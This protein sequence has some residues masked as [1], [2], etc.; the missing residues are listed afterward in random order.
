VRKQKIK[1]VEKQLEELRELRDRS[2]CRAS[3]LKRVLAILLVD[4]AKLPQL[5][6]DLTGF[7]QKYA[8]DLRKKYLQRGI[9][10]LRSKKK[11]PKEL[12]TRGQRAQIAKVLTTGLPKDFGFEA[13]TWT[14]AILARIIEEQFGVRYKSRTSLY[15]IFRQAKFTYHKPD[16]QYKNRKQDLID[17]WKQKVYPE[18]QEA[19]KAPHTVVLVEDEMMLSTQTTTQKVWLPQ[20]QFPK[21]DVSSKRQIRCIYGFLNLKTGKEHAFMT[22][23]ANSIES[24]NVL[25]QIKDLYEGYKIVIVWDNAIWHKSSKI[26]DFLTSTQHRFHLINFPPYSPEINPQ[27]HVW[28]AGRT[29][30]THN[31]FIDDIDKATTKF[32]AFLN[33][34][35][36]DYKFGN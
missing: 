20:G 21:I 5:I 22:M 4:Q 26:K 27:E 8:F 10:S 3:E 17:E 2:D 11:I 13:P 6:K 12:L 14:T 28:K 1:L 33:S 30:I 24:C 9:G 18:I 32:I 29:N 7:N 16:K 31:H 23:K 36:F 35:S 19:L 15:I 25:K 34:Q